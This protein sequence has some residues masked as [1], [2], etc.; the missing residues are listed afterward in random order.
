MTIPANCL[1]ALF[2]GPVTTTVG[3]IA[4]GPVIAPA[5]RAAARLGVDLVVL[6]P[7]R[8]RDRTVLFEF[9]VACDVISLDPVAVGDDR[10]PQAHLDEMVAAGHPV[11]PDPVVVALSR[12][13]ALARR[14][15]A[16]SGFP[17][18]EA[19]GDL[20][21]D[22]MASVLT[23]VVTR[24]SSGWWRAHAVT[25]EGGGALIATDLSAR[26]RALAASVADGLGAKG[27]VAIDLTLA[28]D[29]E[30]LVD[31]LVAGPLAAGPLGVSALEDHL[32]GLLDWPLGAP[33]VLDAATADA[34]GLSAL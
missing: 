7:A 21:R 33:P 16:A 25:T 18:R 4:G 1:D 19:D 15:L 13:R 3:L 6:D 2:A 34:F 29:G 14:T 24:R 23:V 12:D 26:A 10:L 28:P 17:V 5:R 9:A 27:A 31:G 22:A 32:R 30:P 20:E 11:W 8:C